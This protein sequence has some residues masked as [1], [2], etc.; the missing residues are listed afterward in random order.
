MYAH[1]YKFIF[2]YLGN[3]GRFGEKNREGM[4]GKKKSNLGE[5][6]SNLW[7]GGVVTWDSVSG[8]SGKGMQ[9]CCLA[10]SIELWSIS[11]HGNSRRNALH[12]TPPVD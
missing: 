3:L 1:F 11:L 2:G 8:A 10:N 12:V 7:L 4:W 9:S 6:L 5:F